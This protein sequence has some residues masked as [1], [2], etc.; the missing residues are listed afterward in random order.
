MTLYNKS[1]RVLTCGKRFFAVLSGG[2]VYPGQFFLAHFCAI[3]FFLGTIDMHTKLSNII[4]FNSFIPVDTLKLT[5]FLLYQNSF[6]N[7]IF[8]TLKLVR[9]NE[10]LKA[11]FN[12]IYLQFLI[13]QNNKKLLVLKFRCCYQYHEL[14]VVLIFSGSRWVIISTFIICIFVVYS[15]IVVNSIIPINLRRMNQDTYLDTKYSACF[16][17]HNDGA[18]LLVL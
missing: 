10:P 8:V 4:F 17:K 5:L 12:F 6:K 11:F 1:E 7:F 16:H 2:E 9:F 15:S 18:K 13:F 3:V 14:R